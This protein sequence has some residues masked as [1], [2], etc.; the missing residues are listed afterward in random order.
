MKNI[1]RKS[2]SCLALLA[3]VVLGSCSTDPDELNTD[4]RLDRALMPLNVKGT[5]LAT[6]NQLRMNW[7]V[8]SSVAGYEVV[9]Y[10][11]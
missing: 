6:G 7:D 10:S 9:V 3:G 5:V 11:D 8:R 4:F 2:L 1:F